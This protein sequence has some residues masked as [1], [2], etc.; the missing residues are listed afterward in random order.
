MI[1]AFRR[2]LETWVV[3]GF[4]LLV[5]AFIPWGVGDVVRMMARAHLGGQSRRP[6]SKA[7]SCRTP[8]SAGWRRSRASCRQARSQPGNA[9]QRRQRAL[10]GLIGQAALNQELQRLRIVTPDPAV[11]QTVFAIPAFRGPNGQFDQQTFETVLRNN[12]LTEPRFLDMVRGRLRSGS[13]WEPSRPARP[14][15][16]LLIRCSKASSRNGRP[17]GGVPVA[18]APE[19]PAPTEAELQRWY[20]NHPD[21]YS[22]PEYRRIKAVVLS[23]ETL[24][25]DITITDAD[26]RRPISSTTHT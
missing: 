8:I 20:D 14:R 18:A 15:G 7:S 21:L 25:K 12:G 17:N 22:A 24:A 5:F 1:T 23:T 11:R 16:K 26:F 13:C 9:E 3:R 4:F 19:P 2:Y 6:R 10:Q